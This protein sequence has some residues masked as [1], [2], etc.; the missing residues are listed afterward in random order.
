MRIFVADSGAA[1]SDAALSAALHIA[2]PGDTVTVAAAVNVPA[3]LPLDAPAG[4]IWKQVCR[5][6]RTLHGARQF[7]ERHAP[8]GVR[9]QYTRIQGRSFAHVALAGAANLDADLIVIPKP[10]G[11]RGR[12]SAW[13]GTLRGVLDGAPCPVRV[14]GP[15]AAPVMDAIPARPRGLDP[16]ESLHTIAVN[17]A[18]AP[19]PVARKPEGQPAT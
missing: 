10:A 5:A 7:A 4:I 17:P 12:L 13:C 9:L 6:E 18:L 1:C 3:H 19:Q 8:A 14:I 16:F 2:G 11:M 15:D